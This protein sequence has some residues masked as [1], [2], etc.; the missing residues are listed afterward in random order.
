LAERS[1]RCPFRC[2]ERN[3]DIDDRIAASGRHC[4]FGIS[5]D[6]RVHSETGQRV[7]R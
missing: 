2:R 6:F 4:P 7:V 5:K 1:T 3:R